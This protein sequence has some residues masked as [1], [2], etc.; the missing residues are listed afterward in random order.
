[1]SIKME[2][3]PTE[4]ISGIFRSVSKANLKSLRPVSRRFNDVACPMLFRSINIRLRDKDI[5]MLQWTARDPVI[6]CLVRE[7]I[8]YSCSEG[9]SID[10]AM[11]P[12][13]SFGDGSPQLLGLHP[14]QTRA[15][16]SHSA[17]GSDAH[18]VG[19]DK[20]YENYITY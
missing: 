13:W 8:G 12:Y 2:T 10:F 14:E 17:M 11:Y 9:D 4:I 3:L 7:V 18:R 5:E 6:R 1:M 19:F 20:N 16:D 15:Y